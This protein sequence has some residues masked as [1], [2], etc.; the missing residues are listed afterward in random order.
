MPRI[1]TRINMINY[2]SRIL[3]I[4]VGNYSPEQEIVREE[5]RNKRHREASLAIIRECKCKVEEWHSW[6]FSVIHA[7]ACALK[8]CEW[9]R[10]WIKA[11]RGGG[12]LKIKVMCKGRK[13]VSK[14]KDAQVIVMIKKK[15]RKDIILDWTML[16]CH[17]GLSW[18]CFGL[19]TNS[20][21]KISY[22]HAFYCFSIFLY[23]NPYIVTWMCMTNTGTSRPLV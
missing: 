16:L 20:V 19:I 23:Q 13:K 9:H 2:C 7:A 5:R 22:Q 12:W 1:F 6:S 15:E 10:T 18:N 3:Y 4:S 14:K 8:T 17:E 21:E 11:H